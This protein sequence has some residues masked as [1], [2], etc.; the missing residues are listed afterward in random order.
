MKKSH[1]DGSIGRALDLKPFRLAAAA[2]FLWKRR[3]S[4]I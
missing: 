4:A 1:I 3:R 2:S